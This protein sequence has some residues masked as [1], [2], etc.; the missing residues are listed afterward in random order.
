MDPYLC[1]F[2]EILHCYLI[3]SLVGVRIYRPDTENFI[4]SQP[5]SLPETN[6]LYINFLMQS[7]R[8]ILCNCI[9]SISFISFVSE[10][11]DINFYL[12]VQIFHLKQYCG[13]SFKITCYQIRTFKVIHQ[14]KDYFY[15][16]LACRIN[17]N[18]F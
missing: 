12:N 16:H 9:Y 18:C 2:V 8:K 15:A 1:A 17:K 11:C 7:W 13:Q 6:A 14:I 5:E 10:K 4:C 3:Q